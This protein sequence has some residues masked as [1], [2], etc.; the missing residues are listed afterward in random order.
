MTTLTITGRYVPIH[1]YYVRFID[2]GEIVVQDFDTFGERDRFADWIRSG[3]SKIR[4]R[5][6][7]TIKGI[8]RKTVYEFDASDD[9]WETLNEEA[10]YLSECEVDYR[11]VQVVR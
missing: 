11:V 7:L 2:D 1:T 4:R 5:R 3:K 10:L 9:A 8:G 6:D